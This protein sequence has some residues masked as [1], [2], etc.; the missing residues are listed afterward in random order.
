LTGKRPAWYRSG[1]AYYDAG[2][3][4]IIGTE[5]KLRIAGF[6]VSA[7]EGATLT[8]DGVYENMLKAQPGFIMLA[9]ANRPESDT[10]EG[11]KRAVTELLKKGYVF[12][13]L[14]DKI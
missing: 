8:A 11:L 2:A 10:A 12:R 5:L 4:K 9:H 3:L 14:P 6:A 7:D 1:A 13:K